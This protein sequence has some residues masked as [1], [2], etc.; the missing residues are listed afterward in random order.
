M[1]SGPTEIMAAIAT[2]MATVTNLSTTRV[3]VNDWKVQNQPYS[4]LIFPSLGGR[5]EQDTFGTWE[6]LHRITVKL[7]IRDNDPQGLYTKSA[8]MIPLVL[9]WLRNNDRLGLAD[10]ETC[11]ADPLT[12][13]SPTSDA[14]I[15]DGGGVLSR[16]VDF[17]VSVLVAL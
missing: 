17:S 15:D 3:S 2:G 9:T 4:V 16:E 10:V 12:W 13:S 7:R 8:T 6:Q 14:V 1:S 11:H 5:Q